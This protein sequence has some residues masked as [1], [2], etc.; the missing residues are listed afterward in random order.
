MYSK[1]VCVKVKIILN[2]SEK[3]IVKPTIIDDYPFLKLQ[4][5]FWKTFTQYNYYN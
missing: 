1:W 2:Y 5:N 3:K 4:E